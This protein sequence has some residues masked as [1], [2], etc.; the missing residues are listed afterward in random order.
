MCLF[1]GMLFWVYSQRNIPT[2]S[3]SQMGLFLFTFF[4]N[5]CT[6]WAIYKLQVL[7]GKWMQM[8][9]LALQCIFFY[10]TWEHSKF[11]FVA[12]GYR[13]YENFLYT[14]LEQFGFIFPLFIVMLIVHTVRSR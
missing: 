5:F 9:L 6:Q 11:V 8:V 7:C 2:G 13:E 14:P 4:L 3:F 10:W 12:H 1:A